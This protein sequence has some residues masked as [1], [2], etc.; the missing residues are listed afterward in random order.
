MVLKTKGFNPA[1]YTGQNKGN[2][3]DEKYKF[4][5]DPSCKVICGTIGAMGTGL[6]LTAASTVIFLD[7][8]WNR[9]IKDQAEDRAHR[10]GTR[11]TV[12]IVTLITKDS[13]DEGIY[14]LVQKKGKMADLL[15]DGKVD[16][17]NIDSALDYLL[18]FG[19]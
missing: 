1:L 16:G 5:H 9:G 18:S 2:R 13:V 11:G 3:E 12:R 4:K 8:P 6:T 17:R 10:I 19:A 14:N 7:E 15:I